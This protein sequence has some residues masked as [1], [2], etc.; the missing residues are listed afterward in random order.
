MKQKIILFIFIA[1]SLS[2]MTTVQ[3]S[4]RKKYNFNSEWRLHVGR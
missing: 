3:A 2:V 1:F 4:E